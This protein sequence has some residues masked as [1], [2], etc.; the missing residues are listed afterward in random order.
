M[1][2]RIKRTRE[3]SK[4]ISNFVCIFCQDLFSSRE[5]FGIHLRSHFI[6]AKLELNDTREP[7]T[8]TCC[9]SESE[10]TSTNVLMES[11]NSDDCYNLD[12]QTRRDLQNPDIVE[13]FIEEL[14]STY[15]SNSLDSE[16]TVNSV[17]PRR[18][19][20][21]FNVKN[22]SNSGIDV[23][24]PESSLETENTKVEQVMS[25]QSLI[26]TNA[27]QEICLKKKRNSTSSS[28]TIIYNQKRF[29]SSSTDT[30]IEDEYSSSEEEKL[31]NKCETFV[32]DNEVVNE[33]I[34]DDKV[35]KEKSQSQELY[36]MEIDLEDKNLD[37]KVLDL[38]IEMTIESE[39]TVSQEMSPDLP[40]KRAPQALIKYE[41][42]PG[43]SQNTSFN[44]H[45]HDLKPMSHGF[46]YIEAVES[47]IA[48]FCDYQQQLGLKAVECL[49]VKGCPVCDVIMKCN[50]YF[51]NRDPSSDQD[52]DEEFLELHIR[53]HL[54]YYTLKCRFV[55]CA[56]NERDQQFIHFNDPNIKRHYEFFHDIDIEKENI[57]NYV[58]RCEIPQ[59]EQF[60]KYFVFE[61][62]EDNYP[63]LLRL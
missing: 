50:E 23:N 20:K 7:T 37:D 38:L 31:S 3:T 62:D 57:I 21:L 43:S 40:I 24:D 6:L 25:C 56:A 42:V 4:Q 54:R 14:K 29:S 13:N 10:S 33:E 9:E 1:N 53:Q 52:R 18:T 58:R 48:N 34:L 17:E 27:S 28:E 61:S 60:I 2:R 45:K 12:S 26:K 30:V 35:F 63:A 41:P 39:S 46:G 44:D 22:E 55:D 16:L 11:D 36:K 32:K 19:N 8:N 51:Y 59:F 47:W 5:Y 49:I 15:L